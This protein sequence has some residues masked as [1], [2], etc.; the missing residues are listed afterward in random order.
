MK[1]KA[2]Q[3]VEAKRELSRAQDAA[4]KPGLSVR[5]KQKHIGSMRMIRARIEELSRELNEESS[6]VSEDS[7][8][9]SK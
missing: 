3:I 1:T 2:E 9:N 8:D 6:Q 7:P 5:M 4:W